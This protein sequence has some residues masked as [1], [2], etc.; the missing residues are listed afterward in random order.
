MFVIIHCPYGDP[1]KAV[2]FNKEQDAV[3]Y[4]KQN[5]RYWDISDENYQQA[6]NTL[7]T[8]ADAQALIEQEA[9]YTMQVWNVEMLG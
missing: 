5:I 7:K 2:G 9:I 8:V 3:D 6:V 1:E 4:I